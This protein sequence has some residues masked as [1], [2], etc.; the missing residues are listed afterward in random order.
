MLVLEGACA[1]ANG[2]AIVRDFCYDFVPGERI[3]VV[4]R[5][6]TGKSTLL[7]AVAGARPLAAGSR[8]LGETT[9]VAYLTQALPWRHFP[10]R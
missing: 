4:G 9:R 3:G 6:G 1:E 10:S 5:N 7:D 8:V 2:R